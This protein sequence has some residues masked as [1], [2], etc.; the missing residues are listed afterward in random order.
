WSKSL[1]WGLGGDQLRIYNNQVEARLSAAERFDAIASSM[2]L[3][4][5][6]EALES[7][8][9]DLLASQSHDAGLCEYSRWQGDRMAPLDR[10]EDLHNFT[11][12][13]LGYNLLDSA[14]NAGQKVL[15]SALRFV[16]AKTDSSSLKGAAK[17]CTV[18]NPCAWP[19]SD[20]VQTGRIYPIP[21]NTKE[22]VI[23]DQTGKAVPSQLVG[24][25]RDPSGNL[26]VANVAF[27]AKNV[28]SLGYDSYGILF[29]TYGIAIRQGPI[30]VPSDLRAD[31][32][33]LAIENALLKIKLDPNTGAVSSLFDKRT[34]KE[35]LRSG[36]GQY[37]VL[38]G[39][40]DP[41]YPL[42]GN[43]PADY[44]SSKAKAEI[45]WTEGGPV[46][47][48]VKARFGFRHLVFE[49]Y[50][51]LT[52]G[53]P[54]AEV[55]SRILSSVPPRRDNDPKEIKNGY[56]LSFAPSFKPL[57]V[58]RDYPLA[59]EASQKPQFHAL[60]FVD[61]TGP[62]SG[63]LV[64]HPGTQFFR[65]EPD[66]SLSNLVMREWE[67]YY[68]GEWGWPRYAEYHHALEPHGPHFSDAERLRESTDFTDK[69]ITCLGAPHKGTLPMSKSFVQV[70]PAGVQL[71]EFRSKPGGGFEVRATEVEGAS[72]SALVSFAIPVHG[73]QETNVLGTP[74]RPVAVRNGQLRFDIRPWKF[75]TFSLK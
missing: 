63:L 5:Q 33:A 18:F 47:Y 41:G 60:S 69:L 9:K 67:S 12:G 20:I 25:E 10:L 34:G 13:A 61:L 52:S 57:S 22:I 19:R 74:L 44:D 55:T 35:M 8:S 66:G 2:G 30:Q 31:K 71:S 38:R 59:I 46:R 39:Q 54:Y 3:K 15:D 26:I 75:E 6:A 23:R 56:W 53:K 1:T 73:A 28:P 40:P 24:A 64:L 36:S 62:D 14:N 32:A 49:T 68:S 45:T 17:V 58:L 37:P 21:S 43:I 51:S 11:W 29:T 72:A 16:A 50:V 4:S 27:V 42:R 7:A 70:S 65:F 48:T